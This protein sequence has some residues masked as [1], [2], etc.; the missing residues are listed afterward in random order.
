[1]ATEYRTFDIPGGIA[2]EDFSS[3]GGLL[4]AGGTGQYLFVACNGTKDTYVHYK[5]DNP[6]SGQVP[7]GISQN[8]PKN[9][10]ELA[11]RALGLSKV[12][13]GGVLNPGQEVGSDA[14]GRAV[15][16]GGTL[17]GANLGD[18]VMGVVDDPAGAAGEIASVLL[19]GRY[20]V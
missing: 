6:T 2:G 9:G 5:N 8:N 3:A 18:F 10:G 19:I 4:G 11:I 14:N 16:K 20:R 7:V 12:V 15:A 13:A 17:T 1:M